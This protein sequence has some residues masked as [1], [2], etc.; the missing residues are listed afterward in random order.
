M[1]TLSGMPLGAPARGAVCPCAVR[2]RLAGRA[3]RPQP[4]VGACGVLPTVSGHAWPGGGGTGR[5]RGIPK[6]SP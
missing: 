4:Y 2:W 5:G 3:V 1:S 6:Q